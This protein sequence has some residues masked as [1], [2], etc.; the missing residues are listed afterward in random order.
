MLY[1]LQ[2][3]RMHSVGLVTAAG[4]GLLEALTASEQEFNMRTSFDVGNLGVD[5]RP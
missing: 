5:R 4:F 2:R 3:I 1:F